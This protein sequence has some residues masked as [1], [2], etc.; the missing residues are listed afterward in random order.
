MKNERRHELQTNELAVWL[1][2]WIEKIKPYSKAIAGVAILA[3]TIV[4]A[5]GYVNG[6]NQTGEG[7]AWTEYFEAY[8][9]NNPE[10]FRD[11]ADRFPNTEPGMWALQS[12]GDG[13][14]ATGAEQLFRDQSAAKE[15]LEN[16]KQIYAQVA[17]SSK[18]RMLKP[19]A[20]FGSG[21]AMEALGEFDGA[22]EKYSEIVK[23]SEPNGEF[24]SSIVAQLAQ[25]RLDALKQ[26]TVENWYKWFAGQKP[27]QSPLNRPGLFQDLPNLPEQPNLNLPN[28]GELVP[29]TGTNDEDSKASNIQALPLVDPANAPQP[30]NSSVEEK[31]ETS[32]LSSEASD[33]VDS[34][35]ATEPA[36]KAATEPAEKAATEAD[37]S[38][39]TP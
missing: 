25:Q 22:K 17:E 37:S 23:G 9:I 31:T 38:A 5:V 28:P 3:V 39:D 35:A 13:E 26:P 16:A 30:G 8:A 15:S 24:P 34:D 11:V 2:R 12:V 21:Q 7:D 10:R 18:G 20:I 36:E 6:R 1:A 14:L 4:C 29:G 33:N 19:R 27:I 32:P